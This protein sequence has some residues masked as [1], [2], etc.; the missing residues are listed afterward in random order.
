MATL[1][2]GLRENSRI[3][4]KLS[5]MKI[6][7]DT[8]LLAS[9]VDKL[10]WLVWAKTEDA[11]HGTNQPKSV[12]GILTGVEKEDA[13]QSFETREEFEEARERILRQVKKHG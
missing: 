2:V 13:V 10:A 5:G 3:K 8:L 9:T 11:Q 7:T 4:M 6:P 12:V 1:S